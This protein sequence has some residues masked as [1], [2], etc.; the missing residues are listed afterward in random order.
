MNDD[1]D[2]GSNLYKRTYAFA[3]LEQALA[4]AKTV[5]GIIAIIL[6]DFD[7]Y[8]T[9]NDLHGHYYGDILLRTISET[10]LEIVDGK[11]IASR[12]GGD[13][14]LII[15]PSVSPEDAY[16]IAEQIRR[17]TEQ[18]KVDIAGQSVASVTITLGLAFYPQ[19][20]DD[21]NSLLIAAD[22]AV[23]EGKRASGNCVSVAK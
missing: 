2:L 18:L 13:E 19:H 6:T 5:G 11:G 23:L 21:A 12:Y 4:E 10:V 8:K 1:R 7:R 9:F 14:F 3:K 20:G 16:L 15:L 17:K 22:E